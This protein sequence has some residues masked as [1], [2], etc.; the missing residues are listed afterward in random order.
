M[1]EYSGKKEQNYMK[2]AY[3]MHMFTSIMHFCSK[4]ILVYTTRAV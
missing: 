3:D 4:S 2:C 1:Y